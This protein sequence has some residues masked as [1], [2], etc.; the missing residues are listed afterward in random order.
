MQKLI[1]EIAF[2]STEL[3]KEFIYVLPFFILGVAIDSVIRTFK[4]HLKLR[5]AI[6]KLGYFAIPG[7]MLAGV[8]SPVCACGILPVAVSLLINGVPLAPV[9]TVLVSSPLMSPSAY[10]L[11]AWELGRDWANAKIVSS[12]FMG[13]FAGY[14]T[15]FFQK[16]YFK[17]NE[18]FKGETPKHDVHDPDADP[19][20]QCLCHDKL[21]N[22]LASEG[23]NKFIIFGAKFLEGFW[24]IGK[25]TLIGLTVEIIGLRYLPTELIE[26]VIYSRSPWMIP[27]VII[28]SVPLHV[29]QI[30]AAAI[31]YGFIEK[32]MTI[33]WGVGMAFLVG[34]PVTALPVMATFLAMFRKRVF[35]LYLG[36]CLIGSLIVGYTFYFLGKQLG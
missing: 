18:L 7:A 2:L 31:L 34:G 30:T 5:S 12:I 24:A 32:G 27:I 6:E 4:L 16:K 28:S 8:L 10:T 22:R 21:S 26:K 29:N 33:P 36:I 9:M 14:V 11:T 35:C 19:R 17:S 25:F 15:L 3:W 13:L 20:I 23:K 1:Q